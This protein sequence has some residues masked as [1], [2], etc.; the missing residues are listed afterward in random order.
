MSTLHNEV[1]TLNDLLGDDA[2]GFNALPDDERAMAEAE[3]SAW[4]DEV[5]A[6]E[7]EADT[8]DAGAEL[9]ELPVM[10]RVTVAPVRLDPA[11]WSRAAV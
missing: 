5:R 3:Y 8:D 6:A 1:P 11:A 7:A 2:K 4:L 9:A 10:R